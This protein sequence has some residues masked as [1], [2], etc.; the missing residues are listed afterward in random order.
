MTLTTYDRFARI[1]DLQHASFV[2]D[3][4]MYLRLA[5]DVHADDQSILEIGSGSGR[6]MI[7]L[8][9]AGLRVVG[10][11]ESREMLRIAAEH[12]AERCPAEVGRYQLV[13]ADA[14]TLQLDQSF[15]L[16]F[17]ALNTF[18]HNLTRDDQLATLRAIRRHLLDGAPLVVD[19][20]PN[21]E[22]AFQPD[23]GQFQFEAALIDPAT[24]QEIRK[25]VASRIFWATQ[26]QELTFRVE[27]QRDGAFDERFIA[28]RLRHVFRH[29]MDLLLARSGF[30]LPVWY[31]DYQLGPY[32]D[33]SPR[34]IAVA[35]A[36]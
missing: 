7:P 20:P 27:E 14:R 15:G 18:L 34:M 22:L 26:E 9:E 5:N 17:V 3:V 21:D 31:G 16:A 8:I 13:H 6:V 33:T 25:F 4:A 12:L 30:E 11:D 35:R 1:Y 28:F 23:D 36:A 29:E 32:R 19:L 24:G 2:D 10:V